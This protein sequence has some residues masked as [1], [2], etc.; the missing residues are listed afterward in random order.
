MKNVIILILCLATVALGYYALSTV[1]IS[2]GEEGKLEQVITSDLTLPIN[3]TGEVV[4]ARRIVLKAEASG[5]VLEIFKQANEWVDKGELLI[6]LEKSE[7]QRSV[8][9]ARQDQDRAEARLR[10]AEV[11]L[12]QTETVDIANAQAA[13]DQIEASLVVSKFRAESVHKTPESFHEEE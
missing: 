3:A 13:I 10:I 5:E 6:R 4:P 11:V 1:R 7:E 12:E 2:L 8:D 9:R